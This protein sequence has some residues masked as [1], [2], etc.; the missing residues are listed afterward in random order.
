MKILI[1]A[2]YVIHLSTS[3]YDMKLH[4]FIQSS[5]LKRVSAVEAKLM[6]RTAKLIVRR[7]VDVRPGD[8][9]LPA[10]SMDVDSFE[11]KGHLFDDNF[12]I[13]IICILI[14]VQR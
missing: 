10:D 7:R 13:I 6:P 11:G 14:T 9:E 3:Y 2:G 1:A 4:P 8:E 12:S 5:L